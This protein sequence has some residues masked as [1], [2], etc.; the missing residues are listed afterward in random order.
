MFIITLSDIIF[1]LFCG[2]GLLIAGVLFIIGTII[3][4]RKRK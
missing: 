4:K 1:L 3:E 2:V